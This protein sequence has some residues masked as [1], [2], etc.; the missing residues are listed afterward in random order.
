MEN[1]TLS[2]P[3]Q[4]IMAWALLSLLLA[5]LVVFAALAFR[6]QR[7]QALEEDD[8][9]TGPYPV[10]K[11]QVSQPMHALSPVVAHI[12]HP[13]N[14]NGDYVMDKDSASIL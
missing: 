3:T 4:I 6:V 12:S 13:H 7:S 1:S 14:G 8:V 11:L 2:T 10:V 5:W 9:P